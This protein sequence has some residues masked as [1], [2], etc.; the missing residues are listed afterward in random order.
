MRIHESLRPNENES[1]G[2]FKLFES[3]WESMTVRK[4]LRP[5][6]NKSG[7]GWLSRSWWGCMKVWGQTRAKVDE[8]FNSLRLYESDYSRD[9]HQLQLNF[10]QYQTLWECM[11]VAKS[12]WDVVSN[13]TRARLSTR[14]NSC[15]SLSW[16]LEPW[17]LIL[18]WDWT[19]SVF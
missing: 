19:H 3:A 13:Q 10:G 15:S 6:E 16:G 18:D 14:R 9:S 4:S 11:R 8:S 2:E 5:N 17:A 1:E 12:T 7:R